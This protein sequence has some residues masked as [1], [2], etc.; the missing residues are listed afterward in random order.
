[1]KYWRDIQIPAALKKYGAT[2]FLTPG[3]SCS[4]RTSVPQC[5]VLHDAFLPGK[6][7]VFEWGL[8]LFNK[9]FTPKFIKKAT[10]VITV[11]QALKTE[12]VQRYKTDRQKIDV[13]YPGV[14]EIFQPCSLEIKILIKQKYTEGREYFICTGR[15]Y[16]NDAIINLLKAF[17][18]FKKRQRSN[19]KLVITGSSVSENSGLYTLLQTYK[20]REDVVLTGV[21]GAVE[22]AQLIAA[23]YAAVYPDVSHSFYTSLLESMKCGVPCTTAA[24]AVME[25]VCQDAALYFDP[26][27][28]ADIAEKLMLLYKDEVLHADL[29]VKSGLLASKYNWHSAADSIWQSLLKAG[30]TERTDDL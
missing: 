14:A 29:K 9:Y 7:P 18:L 24:S 25:E 23:A 6:P 15:G 22:A 3:L 5:I 11:S 13:T 30:N 8:Q 2:V 1:L 27:N 28:P 16:T 12:I 21:V 19:W 20:Y 10:R 17:S 4:L 26:S